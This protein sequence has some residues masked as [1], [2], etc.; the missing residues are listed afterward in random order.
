M[1]VSNLYGPADDERRLIES[2]SETAESYS[3]A[4]FHADSLNPNLAERKL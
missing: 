3:R 1:G 4:I 2:P